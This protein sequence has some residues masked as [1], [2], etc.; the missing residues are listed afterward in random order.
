VSWR[1]FDQAAARYD[2]W[3]DTPR[4]RRVESAERALLSELPAAFPGAGSLLDVGCGTGRFSAWL[5]PALRVL[6]I[7]RS[8][9]MLTEMRIR[10][11]KISA[12]LGDAHR[13]PLSDAAIDLV[14]FVTTVEFLEDPLTALREAVRVARRGLILIVL[15]RWSVGGL[16]RRVG[17]QARS[18]LL[19]QARDVSLLSLRT[20]AMEAAGARLAALPWASTLFPDGLWAVLAQLPFGDVL[21]MAVVFAEP[22]REPSLRLSPEISRRVSARPLGPRPCTTFQMRGRR[23]TRWWTPLARHRTATRAPLAA[24]AHQTAAVPVLQRTGIHR[25]PSG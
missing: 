4:G 5:A 6:G 25:A 12:V 13:L 7:D 17:A 14:L 21:G 2:A 18:A 11:P 19:A 24:I 16:S 10:D 20:M 15:N 9:G 8:P 23:G 3:Y 1:L 22:N